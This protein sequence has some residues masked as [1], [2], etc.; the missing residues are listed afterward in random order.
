MP[1]IRDLLA[2]GVIWADRRLSV[3][4]RLVGGSF[5]ADWTDI[6]AYVTKFGSIT[7][8]FGDIAFL[9]DYQIDASD[10]EL[11]NSQRKFN[12]EKDPD[13]IFYLKS[14]M[15]SK[16][17]MELFYYDDNGDEVSAITF[18]S[19][20]FKNPYNSDDH[21]ISIAHA[22]YLKLFQMFPASGID[23]VAG[24]TAQLIDRLV[25]KEINGVRIFD[26][27]FEGINDAAKYQINPDAS[28]VSTVAVPVIDDGATIWDKIQDYSMYDDFFVTVDNSGNF[29][30]TNKNETAGTIFTLNGAGASTEDDGVNIISI[31]ELDGAA[32][33]WPRCVIE[34]GTAGDKVISSISWTPGD[35][36][37][38]DLYGEK[39]LE[40]NKA[41]PE[42]SQAEAQAIA[43]SKVNEYGRSI[44]REW[45]VETVV[46][47]LSL[48]DK[49]SLNVFGE[50][51]IDDA[52]TIEESAIGGDNPI[53][54]TSGAFQL[55]E[56]VKIIQKTA[57]IDSFKYS[58][59]IRE[60]A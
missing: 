15:G 9:T 34:Y 14:R 46:P 3:K 44:E 23:T 39:T 60:V 56:T 49:L 30:W 50:P 18:Y 59:Q 58:Y 54:Q 19:F 38:I 55:R 32:N 5:D 17:K 13:S 24:T 10:L 27:Y 57:D 48:K 37:D 11:D 20:I 35:G 8:S 25:K 40:A 28:T 2:R 29:I 41:Y 4:A 52:F 21:K 1:A 7:E 45:S 26:K 53:G 22:P 36:S 42:L 12:N 43:D 6:T 33:F 31:T 47:H 51:V 16:F